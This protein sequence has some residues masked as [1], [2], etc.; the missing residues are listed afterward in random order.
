MIKVIGISGQMSAGKDSLYNLLSHRISCK[1]VALADQLRLEINPFVIDK[2]GIDLFNCSREEKNLVRPIL[3]EYARIK[4]GQTK[5]RYFI[6]K[7]D[8]YVRSMSCSVVITDL[9]HAV[10][11][12]D[13]LYWL[14]N[15]LKGIL[16]HVSK[17]K[18]ID[19]KR[20]FEESPIQDERD[21]DPKMRA[22]ADYL[23]EWPEVKNID[24]LTPYADNLLTWLIQSKL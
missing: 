1:R 13:E 10:Y 18:E 8:S 2:F 17:Y 22:A 4:R 6:D 11:E 9:R 12:R 20:V 19:G 3:V 23:I 5:G 15:E 14:K 16:V 7:V 21:N 24:L